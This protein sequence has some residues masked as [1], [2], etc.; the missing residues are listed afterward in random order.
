MVQVNRITEGAQGYFGAMI[1]LATKEKAALTARDSTALIE[2]PLLRQFI[3]N[4]NA[5]SARCL[6][7][8]GYGNGKSLCPGHH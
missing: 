6:H 8:K 3:G 2:S 4:I 5:A 1:V 7:S